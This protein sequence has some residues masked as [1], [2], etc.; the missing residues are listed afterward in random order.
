MSTTFAAFEAIIQAECNDTST[1]MLALITRWINEEHHRICSMRD[2]DWLV[3][4]KSDSTSILVA[5]VPFDIATIKVATTTTP[6]RRVFAI[7]DTT[8]GSEYPL[9]KTT[10]A[11]LSARYPNYVLSTGTPEFWYYQNDDK[12]NFWPALA[13]TR[14]FVFTYLKASKTYTTASADALLIPDRW[15]KVLLSAVMERVWKYRTDD[16]FQFA[17]ADYQ[18]TLSD[19]NKEAA[20]RSGMLYATNVGPKNRMPTLSGDSAP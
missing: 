16:R 1:R 3:V 9:W 13:A 12:V 6:A 8:D 4:E 19:M 2:W 20:A 7:R 11:E 18:A 15:L 5:S 10:I 14:T 17:A